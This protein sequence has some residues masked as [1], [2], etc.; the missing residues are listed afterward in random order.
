MKNKT[1]VYLDY[2]SIQLP[3]SIHARIILGSNY[4]CE[5]F[6]VHLDCTIFVHYYFVELVIESFHRFSRRFKSKLGWVGGTQSISPAIL[7][8]VDKKPG[9][10]SCPTPPLAE[11]LCACVHVCVRACVCVC[12]WVCSSSCVWRLEQNE[13]KCLSFE[14]FHLR[15]T[16]GSESIAKPLICQILTWQHWHQWG[17]DSI[18]FSLMNINKC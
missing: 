6:F 2:I 9:P 13:R 4:S 7:A 16:A 5:S 8:D 12:I 10:N 1:L 17:I 3:E 11:C 18:R 14:L 15:A